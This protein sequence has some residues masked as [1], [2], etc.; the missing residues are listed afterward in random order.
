MSNREDPQQLRERIELVGEGRHCTDPVCREWVNSGESV[1]ILV[2]CLLERSD[3][4]HAALLKA[5]LD[6]SP[7]YVFCDALGGVYRSPETNTSEETQDE[8]AR[9]RGIIAKL[10]TLP[11]AQTQLH[12]LSLG[13]GTATEEAV[14]LQAKKEVEGEMT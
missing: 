6:E 4:Y 10:V 3:Q 14:W 9:L 11:V 12:K 8:N 5:R 1:K 13:I 7:R 2:G